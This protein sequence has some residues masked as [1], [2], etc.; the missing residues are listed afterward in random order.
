MGNRPSTPQVAKGI[1]NAEGKWRLIHTVLFAGGLGI[2]FYLSANLGHL[3]S[4]PP[5][6]IAVFWPP[7]TIILAALLL[8]P[9]RRWWICFAVMLPAYIISGL[10]AG[11]TIQRQSIFFVANCSEVLVA[12]V[13]LRRFLRARLTFENLRESVLFVAFAVLLG[14]LVSACV[15]S[16]HTVLYTNV[17][18][19]HAWRV[20]F[21]GDSLAHL[22]LT[23][24]LVVWILPGRYPFRAISWRR[25]VEAAGLMIGL[26]VVG[27]YVFGGEIGARGNIPVLLYTPLPLLLWATVRFGPRGTFSAVFI[28]TILAIWH[29]VNGR[30]PFT[31]P[32]AAWNVLFLQLFLVVVSV[33]MMFLVSL[34]QERRHA[35]EALRASY[36]KQDRLVDDLV[37]TF[38]YRHD[39]EGVFDYVSISIT[40]VLGYSTEEFLTHFSEYLTDHPVNQEVMRHTEQSINGVQQPPYE[41]Q[42]YHKDGSERWL[43]VSEIPVRD[44]NGKVAVVE[45]VAHDITERKHWEEALRKLVE[46]TSS[47]FGSAF[48][49][50]MVV[51]L[52]KAL[53]ADYTLIGQVQGSRKESIR[54][55][56]VAADGELADNFEYD[57]AGTPCD[58]VVGKSVCSHISGVAEEFP[59]DTLLKQ[60][61]V[62]GYVGVPLFDSQ[63]AALGIMVALFRTPLD[64]ADLAE[65]ILQIFSSQVGSELERSR[66]E[67]DREK[68]ATQLNQAQKME[69][70]GQLAGGVAHDFNNLLQAILGYG[71][72]ARSESAEEGPVREY[73]GEVLKAGHRAK[74][75]VRQ[76]LAFS[77][78]QV[79]EMEDLDLNE[80]I[81]DLMKMIRRVIGEHITLNILPGHDLGIVRADRGQIAQILTNLCVNSR[82]AMPEGG[83]ITI[84][85]ENA[86]ID[87][88]YCESH[89]WAAPGRYTL[90]SV[91]DTGCGMDDETL[92]QIFE[93]FFTTKELGKGTGLGL[94][95]VYGLVK[96]HEGQAEVHSEVGKGTTFKIYLPVV[97]RSAAV[98]GDKIEGPV[99]GGTETILLAEDDE[100][101]LAVAGKF[102]T[103]AGYTVLT[104]GDGAEALS[105]FAE[106]ADAIDLAIL[107]VV[108]PKL[109]GRAV[110]DRI[111]QTH[112]GT[113]VLFASGYST[114]AVHTNFILDEGLT[115]I[116]KP[117]QR[118][119]LL[120]KVRQT[121]DRD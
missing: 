75:L 58:N 8:V 20:W 36:E 57:L 65:A 72:M 56:A 114:N 86:R 109:G 1:W 85:T 90:M 23:P 98:V 102:L 108:M 7:N 78:R 12:A 70:V 38:L 96:Q 18:Y 73:V 121:L 15:S 6:R 77:R 76:L 119:D 39:V 32:D 35:E 46:A 116:Q 5:D 21:M 67:E 101:V 74:T 89:A 22:T 99:P 115:L 106:H 52:S 29:A 91:T 120:R 80:V 113:S 33:P 84:E 40:Q 43:E 97:E 88:A 44:R 45:G 34:I 112:Q 14:P 94:A 19:G 104:A 62:E 24:L 47:Q 25:C 93:P 118:A 17:A 10:Q 103:N 69:A 117:Y 26:I 92:A 3:L 2:V 13:L 31:T 37:G 81:A 30:G 100:M 66:A 51:Q 68:L 107:D 41:V 110:F 54:T 53:D 11:F 79:L 60:M 48:F 63:H 16:I 27:L 95:T 61:D 55:I 9:A 28:I 4:V 82:D 111:R 105:V 83:T 59:E 42:I 64:R 87:Q 71:E 50:S 49:E